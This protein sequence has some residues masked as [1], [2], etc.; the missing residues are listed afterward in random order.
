MNTGILTVADTRCVRPFDDVEAEA[1][2][3]Q[4]NCVRSRLADV[5][6]QEGKRRHLLK[7]LERPNP[8]WNPP[9]HPELDVEGGAAGWVKKLRREAEQAF[10][11]R[12]RTK[13]Q[14]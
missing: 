13:K 1:T 9:D 3:L 2:R 12:T 5:A 7:V 4:D 8:P 6:R 14:R 10:R 11:K